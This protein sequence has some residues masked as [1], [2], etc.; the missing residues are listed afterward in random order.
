MKYAL[1]PAVLLALFSSGCTVVLHQYPTERPPLYAAQLSGATCCAA[2][3]PPAPRVRI[4]PRVL[5][6][7]RARQPRAAAG[8]IP[9]EAARPRP[10]TGR[11]AGLDRDGERQGARRPPS[12]RQAPRDTEPRAS[13]AQRRARPRAAARRP[14][15]RQPGTRAAGDCRAERAG[16]RPGR[17][18][19]TRCGRPRVQAREAH[20]RS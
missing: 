9:R 3:P 17:N 6:A 2:P 4:S 15:S 19:A 20:E 12:A 14:Q 5:P 13:R 7:E 1:I 16:G 10:A 18:A 8:P 11:A